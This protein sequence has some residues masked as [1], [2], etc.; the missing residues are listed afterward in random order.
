[1]RRIKAKASFGIESRKDVFAL[2]CTY[3]TVI[4]AEQRRS[5]HG[6]CI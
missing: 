1:M 5:H 2:F 4:T 3:F 6:N